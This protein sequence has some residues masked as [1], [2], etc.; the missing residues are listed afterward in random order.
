MYLIILVEIVL[1]NV[2]I[3]LEVRAIPVHK[4]SMTNLIH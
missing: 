2:P 4:V 1:T 3:Q